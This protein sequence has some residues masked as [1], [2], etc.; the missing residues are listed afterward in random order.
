M[1]TLPEH[2]FN[3]RLCMAIGNLH[4]G[5]KDA[6]E[7]EIDKEP[8]K[9][10]D[11]WGAVLLSL[12]EPYGA[13]ITLI[14]GRGN[15]PALTMIEKTKPGCELEFPD[16]LAFGALANVLP[17]NVIRDLWPVILELAGIELPQAEP[18]ID[19]PMSCKPMRNML[20]RAARAGRIYA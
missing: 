19:G 4:S 16:V 11:A 7:R 10:R 12:P 13:P 17:V 18:K 15:L 14:I 20:N 8:G 1:N 9:N 3:E 2:L 5:L 6:V